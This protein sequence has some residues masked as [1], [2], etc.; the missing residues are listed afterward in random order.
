MRRA[1]TEVDS[2]AQPGSGPWHG[3]APAG[4]LRRWQRLALGCG[5]AAALVLA[6]CGSAPPAPAMDTLPVAPASAAPVAFGLMPGDEIEVKVPDAAQYDQIVRVRPDGK[7]ALQV[8][9][10]VHVQGRSPEDVQAEVRERYGRAAGGKLRREYLLQ[11]NDEIDVKFPYQPAFNE[12][13]RVRPDGKIQ[14]QLVGAVQAEGLSPEALRDELRRRYAQHLRVP[15][16]SVI[17][18]SA[19]SQ[20]VQTDAGPGRAGLS[21]LEPVVMVRAF[22]APQVYVTGEA[23]RPGMLPFVPGMTLMQAMAQAG[24]HLPTADVSQLVLVR[25]GAAGQ[26]EVI[27]P[28]LPSRYLSAPDRDVVL[29]PFDIV[30]LPPSRIAELGQTLDQYLFKI[31]PPLRNSSFG[32]VYDLNVKD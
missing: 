17:L 8:I 1:C 7:V 21:R 20:A 18:R 26:A 11:A 29:Q 14:L 16:L 30:L 31:L 3:V 13:L 32:F 25:R 12:Q 19:S 9:G 2:T 22:Q 28:G 27:R 5:L 10:T 23:A 24:G 4:A 6:G 15:E